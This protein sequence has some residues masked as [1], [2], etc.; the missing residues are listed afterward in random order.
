MYKCMSNSLIVSFPVK[1][2]L[3]GF[4]DVHKTMLFQLLFLRFA[5]FFIASKQAKKSRTL[6]SWLFCLK[7]IQDHRE[8]TCARFHFR[9]IS[10][11]SHYF[12]SK[13]IASCLLSTEIFQSWVDWFL[14]EKSA[15]TNLGKQMSRFG[16]CVFSQLHGGF[17]G[18]AN[19]RSN[20]TF[21][22]F[23]SN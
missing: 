15:W 14:L 13:F 7:K 17:Q 19:F 20:R 3:D 16:D 21:G 8:S 4:S 18:A 6:T 11:V 12:V 23:I 5:P 2:S 9:S 22:W 1:Y 10:A